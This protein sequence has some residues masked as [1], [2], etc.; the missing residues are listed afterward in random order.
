MPE[1]LNTINENQV[2]LVKPNADNQQQPKQVKMF[3]MAKF[4]K[5]QEQIEEAKSPPEPQAPTIAPKKAK[6]KKKLKS[7]KKK[8]QTGL[9]FFKAPQT[10][11]DKHIAENDEHLEADEIDA[12]IAIDKD[13]IGDKQ[14]ADTIKPAAQEDA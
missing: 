13:A 10:L 8:R 4:T 14:F 12:V 9:N 1:F 11:D 2:V 6:A 7:K 3:D 5:E